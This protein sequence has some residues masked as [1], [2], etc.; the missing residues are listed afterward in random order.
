MSDRCER[1]QAER[2]DLRRVVPA[3]REGDQPATEPVNRIGR[4]RYGGDR[5]AGF[6]IK[7]ADF[8]PAA[9]VHGVDNYLLPRH[10]PLAGQRRYH[11]YHR[12]SDHIDDEQRK[13]WTHGQGKSELV[14]QRRPLEFGIPK[15]HQA[16]TH[17]RAD[18]RMRGGNGH[19]GFCRQ[20]NPPAGADQHGNVKALIQNDSLAERKSAAKAL[21]QSAGNEIGNRPAGRGCQRGI[22]QRRKWPG[23]AESNQR[24]D[25]LAVVVGPIGKGQQRHQR[26]QRERHGGFLSRDPPGSGRWL[27]Y[28]SRLIVD[29]NLSVE[30]REAQPTVRVS[31]LSDKSKAAALRVIQNVSPNV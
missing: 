22:Y 3:A 21:E 8:L 12:P 29:I 30:R 11:P 4:R 6:I 15:R 20:Q 13:D 19:S 17:E 26:N 2:R 28:N 23:G 27:Y 10:A 31:S 24:R 25:S 5:L 18:D 7:L 9:D 14:P 1:E 16:R